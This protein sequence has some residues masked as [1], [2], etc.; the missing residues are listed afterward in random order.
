MEE[1]KQ[2]LSREGLEYDPK[3]ALGVMIETPLLL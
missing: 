2:E 3:I 1:C